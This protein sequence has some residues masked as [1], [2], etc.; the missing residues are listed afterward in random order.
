[1]KQTATKKGKQG[2]QKGE[3]AGAAEENSAGEKPHYKLC[4]IHTHTH[5][6][7]VENHY[8]QSP[9]IRSSSPPFLSCLPFS[10][11]YLHPSIT[12][13]TWS[14]SLQSNPPCQTSWRRCWR[15][16]FLFSISPLT[17]ASAGP[18]NVLWVLSHFE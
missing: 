7:T 10:L 11:F 2:L 16:G 9:I 1:M 14:S 3:R 6:H 13:L 17:K 4:T 15:A 5:T 8:K 12:P 18:P